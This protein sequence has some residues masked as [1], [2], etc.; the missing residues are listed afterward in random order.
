MIAISLCLLLS[1]AYGAADTY[2]RTYEDENLTRQNIFFQTGSTIYF[3]SLGT[4]RSENPVLYVRV[5]GVEIQVELVE[6]PPNS[7]IYRGLFH[8]HPTE[9]NEQNDVIRTYDNAVVLLGSDIDGDGVQG[10]TDALN[11]TIDDREPSPPRWCDANATPHGSVRV[12]WTEYK[13]ADFRRYTVVRANSEDFSDAV[14]VVNISDSKVLQWIDPESNL[15]S[16]IPYWYGVKVVDLAGNPSGVRQSEEFAVPI[17]D[18]TAPATVLDLTGFAPEED[19]SINLTWQRSPEP[20]VVGYNIYHSIES[21]EVSTTEDNLVGFARDPVFLH[22]SLSANYRH[23][24]VVVAFDESENLSP[25]SEVF[26]K[27]P[28]DTVPPLP[29]RSLQ[30]SSDETGYVNLTWKAPIG[31]GVSMYRIYRA[32]ESGA[33]EFWNPYRTTK[34]PDFLDTN[35][36]NGKIYFYVVRSYDAAGNEDNNTVEVIAKSEDSTPPMPPRGLKAEDTDIGERIKLSWLPPGGETPSEY[37]IFRSNISGGQNFSRQLARVSNPS[38]TDRE[39]VDGQKYFYVVRSVD[40]AGNFETNTEEIQVISQ[41]LTP[42]PAV[43]D[44]SA[45]PAQGGKIVISWF[46]P[47]YGVDDPDLAKQMREDVDHYNVYWNTYEGFKPDPSRVI[48]TTSTGTH[49]TNLID[50]QAYYYIVRSIDAAGNENMEDE[51][52]SA[53][54]VADTSPPGAPTDLRSFQ[55]DD[56]R[57][58]IDWE[59]P[60]GEAPYRYNIYRSGSSGS[61]SFSFPFAMV[62]RETEWV[63]DNVT[64]G[65]RYFYV[66]RSSDFLLNEDSN[67]IEIT[68]VSRDSTPP[69]PPNNLM[70]RQ[71]AKGDLMINWTQPSVESYSVSGPRLADKAVS[72]RI[73]SATEPG[74]QDFERPITETTKLYFVDKGLR[75]GVTYYYVVRSVDMAGNEDNNRFEVNASADA[76]PPA[77]PVDL[78]TQRATTG[79]V[80]VTWN[81]PIG[82]AVHEY[83]LYKFRGDEGQDF[84]EPLVVSRKNFFVDNEVSEAVQ[85]RYV[86]RSVDRAGNEGKNTNEILAPVL[87]GPP[88]NL[89]AQAAEDGVIQLSW[90]P[91]AE[92]SGSVREYHV[93]RSTRPGDEDANYWGEATMTLFTD[94]R[95]VTGGVTQ[96][97]INGQRYYY[98]V[99]AVDLYGN[100]GLK[101]EEASAVS[102][103]EPPN[104]PGNLEAFA[105]DTGDIQLRW[106]TPPGERVAK[107][108]IYR[109]TRSGGFNFLN[110]IGETSRIIYYDSEVETG[111]L[112][113]YVVRA[114]DE[115]GNEEENEQE[116]SRTAFDRPPNPPRNLRPQLRPNGSVVL[117]WNLP[118]GEPVSYYNIYRAR[119]SNA[120]D[121][122]EPYAVS[123][124][125]MFLDNFVEHD[126][127]YYYVVRAVDSTGNEEKNLEEVSIRSVDKEPPGHPNA[128]QASSAGTGTILLEWMPPSGEKPAAYV[129]YRS[130]SPYFTPGNQNYL[131]ESQN[132]EYLDAGLGPEQTFYYIVRSRDSVGNE[133]DNTDRVKATT[134]PPHPTEQGAAARP[135]GD[136][137][138]T[139]NI[140]ATQVTGFNVYRRAEGSNYDFSNAVASVPF[141]SNSYQ[142]S[143][144]NHSWTYFYVIRSVGP[145]GAEESNTIEVS[146]TSM[147]TVPPRAPEGF[148]T[149]QIPNGDIGLDWEHPEPGDVSVFR[150]YRSSTAP[151]MASAELVRSTNLTL[152]ED[153][154]VTSGQNYYYLVRAVDIHGNEEDNG[155][156]RSVMSI[157]SLPPQPPANLSAEANNNGEIELEWA[158]PEE[159]DLSFNIYRATSNVSANLTLVTS[160]NQTSFLDSKLDNGKTYYYVVRAMDL[161]GNE[162]GNSVLASATASKSGPR[163]LLAG[164][165]IALF[166]VSGYVL[167]KRRRIAEESTT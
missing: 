96:Y 16:G 62:F 56:G 124:I 154:N 164:S 116:V 17:N 102:D 114:V 153:G 151:N 150:I 127:T 55:L 22:E 4:A 93:Y 36:E 149:Y 87:L 80:I 75:D 106:T 23:F 111:E 136:I 42:P 28:D 152:F 70:V 10:T 33:Q 63:D 161:A 48:S 98:F 67:T 119:E 64:D 108:N 72:Y 145:D 74:T 126:Q 132:P 99:R 60:A 123:E 32:M 156:W 157:D 139:W 83:R 104:P 95:R 162:G 21:A 84:T 105:L 79:E 137:L 58:R 112:Y 91:P 142:D 100:A 15:I 31:E 165:V 65:Q 39:V 1:S 143:G 29:P 118:T 133:D 140:S 13:G 14:D 86:I 69:S 51:K 81:D 57:L 128:L 34:D 131:N 53:S 77:P 41:D 37:W 45:N 71:L 26:N 73:Y 27:T 107:Y 148:D 158:A 68:N 78:A 25:P 109:S 20:D 59:P 135:N 52:T 97:M 82:E 144:L 2:L 101:S 129:I 146:A 159:G 43:S 110:P 141:P 35:V 44:V 24:Y 92:G 94:A 40:A 88:R 90:D 11:I 115:A 134:P 6:T 89:E 130:N 163:I 3:R 12:N 18:T 160:T 103:S 147:E 46:A 85:Y 50:G 30:A 138:L 5:G 125:A 38:F 19:N 113:Y 121:F 122:S 61:H 66:V 117:T 47:W 8:T 54:A 120:Q 7:G 167:D 155:N 49:H 166:V 76:S 9:T